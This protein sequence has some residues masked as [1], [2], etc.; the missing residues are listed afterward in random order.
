MLLS[1]ILTSHSFL[2]T[3]HLGIFHN[4]I[5][6][7]FL[8]YLTYSMP[9]ESFHFLTYFALRSIW[10]N[11]THTFPSIVLGKEFHV[12]ACVFPTFSAF[13]QTFFIV[14]SII[15]PGFILDS[16]LTLTSVLGVL[17]H[18]PRTNYHWC[19]MT[20]KSIPVALSSLLTFFKI[21]KSIAIYYITR[22]LLFWLLD[23]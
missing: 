14:S 9:R 22:L 23:S 13:S 21:I 20:L 10:W 5:N 3:L 19:V 16:L 15:F 6:N 7:H 17:T 18:G 8:A 11:F 2:N 12:R 1:S 4:L